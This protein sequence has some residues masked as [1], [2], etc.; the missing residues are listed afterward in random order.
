MFILKEMFIKTMIYLFVL[1]SVLIVDAHRFIGFYTSSSIYGLNFTVDHIDPMRYNIIKYAF[2]GIDA[3]SATCVIR[4]KFA[5]A[6]LLFPDDDTTCTCCARGSLNRLFQ[7][8]RRFPHL[9]TLLAVGGWVWSTNFSD[10][11][12]TSERRTSLAQSCIK[13]M[14]D[15]GMDGI[16]IDWEFPGSATTNLGPPGSVFRNNDGDNLVEFVKTT[17]GLLNAASAVSLKQYLLTLDVAPLPWYLSAANYQA[18]NGLLDWFNIMLYE[19]SL[20]GRSTT[21]HS[22]QL[23]NTPNDPIFST[24]HY[25]SV[26]NSIAS[27]RSYGISND[28]LVIG[29]PAYGRVYSGV[30]ARNNGLFQTFSGGSGDLILY[31]DVLRRI[32]SG[33]VTDFYDAVAEASYTF[34]GTQFITY[35]SQRSVMAKSKY[36]NAH[37][38]GGLM[39]WEISKDSYGND[40]LSVAIAKTLNMSFEDKHGSRIYE[41]GSSFCNIRGNLTFSPLQSFQKRSDTSQS[42]HLNVA[43]TLIL[44]LGLLISVIN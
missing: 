37:S 27:F 41:P 35:E 13:I 2:V 19:F 12:S 38:V 11:V 33:S 4:D 32:Q 43:I 36:V 16:D 25:L 15:Y 31:P 29:V 7:L 10:A 24:T 8:K 30:S 17:R 6:E 39:L 20:N 26:E 34:N 3:D 40:S 18:L 9:Q 1:V 21:R 22:A 14:R 44:G 28:K 42:S 5:D 23:F